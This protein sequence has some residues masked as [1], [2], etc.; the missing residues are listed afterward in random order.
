MAMYFGDS[1]KMCVSIPPKGV[2]Q[3]TPSITVDDSGLI[4][5]LAEQD[6]GYVVSGIA[7]STY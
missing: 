4:T 6:S 2:S 5:A 1:G 7:S 3:A